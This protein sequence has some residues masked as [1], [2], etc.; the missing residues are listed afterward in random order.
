MLYF[1]ILASNDHL[2]QHFTD[3]C[4][5]I[6][7]K[8]LQCLNDLA[9]NLM[10]GRVTV[11]ELEILNSHMTQLTKLFSPKIAEITTGDPHFSIKIVI[12]QRNSEVQRFKSYCST[13]RILVEHCKYISNGHSKN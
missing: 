3:E 2:T 10:L 11:K 5:K 8:A 7:A 13:V 1:C 4:V 6:C 12:A 9:E